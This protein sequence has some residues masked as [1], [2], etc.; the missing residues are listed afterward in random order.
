MI[1]RKSARL[2]CGVG[3]NDLAYS[4]GN[5]RLCPFYQTWAHMMKRCYSEDQQRKRPTYIG[6]TVSSEWIYFSNFKDW[7][8][9]QTWLGNE[10]DKDVLVPGNKLYSPDTCVFI[11]AAL[12]C[13]LTERGRARGDYPLGVQRIKGKDVYRS[14]CW[15]PFIGKRELVGDFKDPDSAHAAW[16]ARKH[17]HACRYADMQTDLR[18]AQALRTRYLSGKETS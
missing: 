15:N 4:G 7:M 1:G 6:C 13:F 16:R 8:Q 18:I 12:N 3:I 5:N 14:R 2:V 10:L 9:R 17:Q 11:S